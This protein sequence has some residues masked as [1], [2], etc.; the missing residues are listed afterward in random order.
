Q[1]HQQR[2]GVLDSSDPA[3]A[4]FAGAAGRDDICGTR[5]SER[6]CLDRSGRRAT[7]GPSTGTGTGTTGPTGAAAAGSGKLGLRTASGTH[8]A[9]H[10]AILRTGESPALNPN[11]RV[12]IGFRQRVAGEIFEDPQRR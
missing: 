6:A 3:K 2:D 8:S 5:R 12:S 9:K 4:A 1:Q 7:A 10:V 11:W